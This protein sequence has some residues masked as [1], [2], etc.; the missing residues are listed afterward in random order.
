M[1]LTFKKYD[2]LSSEEFKK[3]FDTF[4]RLG[5][6]D[7][8]L[9]IKEIEEIAKDGGKFNFLNA[10]EK[11]PGAK[12]LQKIYMNTDTYWKMNAFSG[13]KARYSAAFN[14]AGIVVDDIADELIATRIIKRPKGEVL[15]DVDTLDVLVGDIVKETMPI[16]SRVPEAI[17][18]IR[19]VPVVGAFA[20]FPQR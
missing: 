19:K 7:E 6:R 16:Y 4:G 1:A 15:R 18:L 12:P 5:L 13:E 20:S 17:K 10:I 11:V 2:N 9:A 14:K 3:F 8:N